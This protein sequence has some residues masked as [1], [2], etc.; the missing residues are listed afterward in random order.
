MSPVAN[1]A[2][3]GTEIAALLGIPGA[4]A[5]A[6]LRYRLYDIDVLINRAVVYGLLATALTAIYVGVVVGVG[7]L[8]G[9]GGQ[10]DPHDRRR[11]RDRAGLPAVAAPGTTVGEPIGVRGPGFAVRGAV[12]VRGTDG[13]D[14]RP[15]WSLLQRMAVLILAQGTGAMRR[16]RVLRG[17][18]GAAGRDVAGRRDAAGRDHARCGR[19]APRDRGR[20]ADGRGAVT[21]PSCSARSRSRSRGTSR[22][23]TGRTSSLQDLASQAG[24]VLRNVRLTAELQA[25]V[26]E[27]RA[28]RRP[29]GCRR[30]TRSAARSSGTSTT[31][32]SSSSWR[33]R[34]SSGCS[35]GWPRT[36]NVSGRRRRSCSRRSATPHRRPARPRPRH[37]PASARRPGPARR[38][39]GAGP[40]GRRRDDDRAR[41]GG[42]L[43]ARG[44][45]GR[46]L[47]RA[48]GHAERR[49]VLRGDV[50]RRHARRARR[51]ARVR[52]HATTVAGSIRRSR[53]TGAVCRAWPTGST[54]SEESSRCGA[55]RA[56]APACVARSGCRSP[57]R[58]D[59]ST[60]R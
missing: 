20:D 33:S 30:R 15:R 56:R 4:I 27:L 50:G 48:R 12:G 13:R 44:R 9:S 16:R 34:C 51:R 57:G 29:G 49:E 43:S 41:R 37:L 38:A 32:R 28:S 59:R 45:G 35:S 6:I 21:A 25:S 23:T 60:Q 55:R 18:R 8:V 24:L 10:L 19:R 52:D 47:L 5:I 39:P 3:Y 11:R 54:R 1:V 14:V 42:P 40:Q 46:L 26:D 2:F 53:T 22:S 7:A 17:R 36:R 58:A 31:A